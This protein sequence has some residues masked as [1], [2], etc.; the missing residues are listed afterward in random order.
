MNTKSLKT[1]IFKNSSKIKLIWKY[2]KPINWNKTKR[3][4]LQTLFLMK[5]LQKIFN[6]FKQVRELH[7]A[8]NSLAKSSCCTSSRTRT[9]NGITAS[10][11]CFLKMLKEPGKPGKGNKWILH[12]EAEGKFDNESYLRGEKDSSWTM[13][14]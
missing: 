2:I 6:I 9:R 1:N 14:M 12:P 8:T 5:H 3:A 11:D 4:S 10:D 13:H 7:W